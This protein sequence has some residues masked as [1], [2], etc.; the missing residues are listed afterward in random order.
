MIQNCFC[1]PADLINKAPNVCGPLECSLH[2]SVKDTDGHAINLHAWYL[3]KCSGILNTCNLI[4]YLKS[5]KNLGKFIT[6]FTS[7]HT[8]NWF[9]R[10]YSYLSHFSSGQKWHDDGCVVIDVSNSNLDCCH[11]H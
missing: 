9:A 10:S 5:H 3:L 7:T 4:G 1:G 11:V 8:T 6:L 2:D